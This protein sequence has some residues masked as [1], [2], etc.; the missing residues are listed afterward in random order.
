MRAPERQNNGSAPTAKP[1]S[2]DQPPGED[3]VQVNDRYTGGSPPPDPSQ[4]AHAQH[5]TGG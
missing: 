1:Q 4:E 5:Q 2:S 3:V